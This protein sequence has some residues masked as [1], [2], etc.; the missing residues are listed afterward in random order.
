M[1]KRKITSKNHRSTHIQTNKNKNEENSLRGAPL[2]H[3][4][5][6]KPVAQG[7]HENKNEDIV[8]I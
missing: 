3:F 8:L 4:G 1:Q 6:I 2:P 5:G 7:S